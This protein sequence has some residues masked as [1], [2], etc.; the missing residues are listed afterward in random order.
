MSLSLRRVPNVVWLRIIQD[1]PF[2]STRSDAEVR[3]ELHTRLALSITLNVKATTRLHVTVWSLYSAE[4][5]CPP[6]LKSGSC[7]PQGY[8]EYE[9]S[10]APWVRPRLLPASC[11]TFIGYRAD[12]CATR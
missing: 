11:R 5:C 3:S 8:S 1:D 10:S 2:F 9:V 4:A 6:R 12:S 7:S